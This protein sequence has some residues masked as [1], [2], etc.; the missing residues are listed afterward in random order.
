MDAELVLSKG[1]MWIRDTLSKGD[2]WI[3]DA[4]SKGDMW[5]RLK[6]TS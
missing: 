3:S 6:G 1:D 2:M 4:L 5:I